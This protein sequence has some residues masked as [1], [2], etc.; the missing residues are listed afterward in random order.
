MLIPRKNKLTENNSILLL[1]NGLQ[2][3]IR[4]AARL[5]GYAVLGMSRQPERGY[6]RFL[7]CF[8]NFRF[9]G[10]SFCNTGRS[11]QCLIYAQILQQARAG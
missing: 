9:Q 5:Y 2:H 11:L 4:F 3:A 1:C 10:K 7:H 6:L 8:D